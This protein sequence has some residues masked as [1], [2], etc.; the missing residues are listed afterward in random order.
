MAAP[1]QTK[2]QLTA[3]SPAERTRREQIQEAQAAYRADFPPALKIDTGDQWYRGSEPDFNV[4]VPR[5]T[6]IVETGLEFLFGEPFTLEVD[7]ATEGA[8]VAQQWL[9]E[10]WGDPDD[11]MTFWSEAGQNGFVGG[12]CWVKVVPPEMEGDPP[13]MIVLEPEYVSVVTDPH[14]KRCVLAFRIQYPMQL[15]ANETITY[16]EYIFREGA[17]SSQW[18]IQEWQA[19]NS[20]TDFVLMD[21]QPWPYPFPPIKDC[22]NLTETCEYYGKTDLGS[23]IIGLNKSINLAASNINKV[24]WHYGH[25]WVYGSGFGG[26]T[27]EPRPGQVMKFDSPDAK[28]AAITFTSDLA[29]LMQ[30]L[31]NLRADMDEV[32]GVPSVATGRVEALPRG[33]ISGIAIEMLYQRLIAKTKKKRRLYGRL[34]RDLSQVYLYFKN[35]AWLTAKV[36][37]HWPEMLP[38]DELQV[39]QAL[40]IKQQLGA[41]NHT[42]FAEMGLNYDE[43]QERKQDEAEDSQD[44]FNAGGQAPEATQFMQ[45]G[46]PVQ[47]PQ[48]NGPFVK[49]PQEGEK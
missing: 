18:T 13:E 45:Q 36:H 14:N 2:Q 42:I 41:S 37:I 20:A 25:P 47:P 48:P 1:A 12:H 7:A 24:G 31:A 23:P 33:Q 16:C 39:L 27:L 44:N 30:F 40:L 29:A 34:I 35:P 46:E 38:V 43:E 15:G 19:T 28:L 26:S 32:T 5:S 49:Q 22:Q 6:S 9:D 21:E 17:R 3:L 8:A 10:C 11:M 4:N